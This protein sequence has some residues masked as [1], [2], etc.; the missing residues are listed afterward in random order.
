MNKPNNDSFKLERREFIKTAG[1]AAS[2]GLTIAFTGL[3]TGCK[4]ET[5]MSNQNNNWQ[6]WIHIAHS[7][8]ITIY[9]PRIE[10][11][12]GA[13]TALAMLVAEELDADWQ[14]IKVK[15]APLDD[16]YG[17]LDTENSDSV[18]NCSIVRFSTSLYCSSYGE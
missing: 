2:A 9:I 7:G 8:E 14:S 16:Q 11:G 13:T 4:S 12:Q 1:L 18:C 6:S 17:R 5:G 3:A 10:M 15:P